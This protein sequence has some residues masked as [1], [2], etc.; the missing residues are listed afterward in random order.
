VDRV[1]VV[2]EWSRLDALVVVNKLDL[3]PAEP[4]EVAVYRRMGYRVVGTSAATGL[5]IDELRAALTGAV[6]V[7]TGHSGVGKSSLLN[8]VEPGLGLAVGRLER[9]HGPRSP[10][11]H[12]RGVSVRSAG[13][14]ALVNTPGIRE[15]GL[16]NVPPR[17]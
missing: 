8:A 7:I 9:G 11:H 5:G 2:A 6:S 1:L 4:P 13:G 3:V 10:D 12:V 16:Y 15:F 14:G 17:G